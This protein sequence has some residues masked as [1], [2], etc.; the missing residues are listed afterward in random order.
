[1]LANAGLDQMISLSAPVLELIYPV[2]VTLM[3]LAFIPH[4]SGLKAAY[5]LS[6]ASALIFSAAALITGK[7]FIWIPPV[8]IAAAAGF[9]IGRKRS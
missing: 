5:V 7:S 4:Q 3:A 8:I 9:I 1:M 2:A 6:A